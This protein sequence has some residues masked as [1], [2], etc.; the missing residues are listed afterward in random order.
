M[1]DD[2]N[3][4]LANAKKVLAEA[5]DKFPSPSMPQPQ[6]PSYNMAREARKA[7]SVGD[8][9]KAKKDMTDKAKQALNQ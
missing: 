2:V 9:L 6:K 7:P 5:N 1:A 3:T 4:I 8:E